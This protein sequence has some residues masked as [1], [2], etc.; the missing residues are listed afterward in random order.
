MQN[1]TRGELRTAFVASVGNVLVIADYSQIEL[2]AAAYFSADK[3]MIEAFIKPKILSCR[4]VGKPRSVP[5][6]YER[7]SCAKTFFSVPGTERLARV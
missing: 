2:R 7:M 1:I 5:R 3:R 4:A 6:G